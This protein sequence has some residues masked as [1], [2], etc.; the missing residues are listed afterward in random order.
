M[1]GDFS[2]RFLHILKALCIVLTKKCVE[3][4]ITMEEKKMKTSV[5][6]L[7]TVFSDSAEI[8]ID[9]DF[10]MPDYCPQIT[11]ILKCR[12]VSRISSKGVNG[13]S[14]SVEGCVA[15][16]VMYCD[17]FSRLSSYEYQ[18]PFSK[19][20]ETDM[21]ID[22]CN[23]C[24]NTKCEYIN[25]R[26]V[27]SRK[28][29]IHGAVGV[30]ITLN[31][32]KC[33]EVISD[34]D[35]ENIELRRG[36]APATSPMGVAEK[37]L[38]LEE[39]IEIGQGQPS[40]RSLIR[41][42]TATAVRECKIL[43]GKVMIKGELIVRMLYCP[44]KGEPQ[45]VRYAVPFSQLLEID[46]IND[47]CECDA[48]VKVSFLELKPRVS[49]SGEARS[50]MM[51][52]KLLICCECYCNNDL[53]II[54][55]AYSRK[56]EADI[57]KSEINFSKISHSICEN[58]S[59]KKSLDFP[60]GAIA[61][62]VD[63]WCEAKVENVKA[64][65]GHLSVGGTILA[66]IIAINSDGEP[67]FFERSM[68]FEYQRPINCDSKC[69]RCEP[70]IEVSSINYTLTSSGNMELRTELMINAAVY[71][72]NVFPLITDL[73]LDEKHKISQKDRGAMT[74]YFASGG[75]LIWD[76][77]RHYC[78]SVEEIKK[79]NDITTEKIEN[80]RMILVPI[81]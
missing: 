43:N 65:D 73:I 42:D 12:A 55:D 3:C 69:I 37:Y 45:T 74:I 79:I 48:S 16:T 34:I 32:R 17:E 14:I 11:K 81:N 77:A 54:L 7:D 33:T 71:E 64:T 8:P 66:S 15:I 49:A 47:E 53:D 22:G 2:D 46:G 60:D 36:I 67:T 4:V 52:A 6:A 27:T 72:C 23:I 35:D 39:E 19:A 56:F 61:S 58:F 13:R 29:D 24:C 31:K 41:Y 78:A 44:E 51:D 59:C 70:Q 50:F 76:I 20:F 68:P 57:K 10:T 28:I 40:I 63:L 26:A 25:C 9:V 38:L 30:W 5:F 1:Q 75:E 80:N 18:Y 62:V 21:D